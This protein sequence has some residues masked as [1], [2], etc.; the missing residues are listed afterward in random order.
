MK[1]FVQICLFFFPWAIR[2]RILCLLYKHQIH[3]E[4]RIGYA[5]ILAKKIEMARK[6]RIQHFV[7]CRPIDRICME[8]ESGIGLASRISGFPSSNQRHYVHIPSRKCELVLGKGVKITSRHFLDCNGGIYVG[9]YSLIAGLRSQIL[10]HSIDLYKN[11]QHAA[12]VR[13]GKY[14]FI[15]TGCIILPGAGIPDYCV[16]GA[17][18]VLNKYYDKPRTLYAGNPAIPKKELNP[19]EILWMKRLKTFTN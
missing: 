9:D 4:A 2:R 18:A 12:P 16:L 13:I 5:I 1:I 17:G 6:A 19:D 10:T 15:G 3:P 11:R 14:C 7:F 8:G